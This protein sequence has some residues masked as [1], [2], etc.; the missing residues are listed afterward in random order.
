MKTKLTV[1]MVDFWNTLLNG[2]FF[3]LSAVSKKHGLF[4]KRE[5]GMEMSFLQ[6][7]RRFLETEEF[8]D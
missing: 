4:T 2:K 5:G 8:K 1:H 6:V 3:E 7:T